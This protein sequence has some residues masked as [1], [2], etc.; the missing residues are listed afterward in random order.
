MCHQDTPSEWTDLFSQLL[1]VLLADRLGLV[2]AK[3]LIKMHKLSG[4]HTLNFLQ[5]SVTDAIQLSY[6][7]E[8]LLQHLIT[9]L[10]GLS[11]MKYKYRVSVPL[12]HLGITM[13]V[14]SQLHSILQSSESFAMSASQTNLFLCPI[15]THFLPT[16]S[17]N[18][19]NIP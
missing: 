1:K 14:Q 10:G 3:H 11:L 13:Q 19:E 16:L 17:V 4:L 18:S 12:A 8:N 5:V 6:T 2:F 9:I 15:L 7:T